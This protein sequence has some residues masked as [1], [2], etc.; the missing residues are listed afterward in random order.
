MNKIIS[1]SILAADFAKLGEEVERV[2]KAGSDWIHVDV[3]DGQFVSSLTFGT[4][5]LNS[6]RK[7]SDAY[8]DCHMLVENP[9]S[10]VAS[11]AESGASQFTFHIETMPDIGPVRLP[12]ST[13][14]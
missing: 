11:M 8:F 12:G 14:R 7:H 13:L 9:E 10:W 5:V 3:M 6:L 4:I 1:A 2:R